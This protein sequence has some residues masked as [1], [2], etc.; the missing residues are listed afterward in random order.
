MM[1]MRRPVMC[2]SREDI[3]TKLVKKIKGDILRTRIA[4]RDALAR[5]LTTDLRTYRV[6]HEHIENKKKRTVRALESAKRALDAKEDYFT[7]RGHLALDMAYTKILGDLED[8]ERALRDEL[9]H[10][11]AVVSDM[12]EFERR[13][14]Y[15]KNEFLFFKNL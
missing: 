12:D 8:F 6:V 2:N 14:R 13:M 3:K 10:D 11:D 15:Q 1:S 9:K 5:T 4:E 7:Q